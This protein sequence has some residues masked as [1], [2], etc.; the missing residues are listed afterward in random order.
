MSNFQSPQGIVLGSTEGFGFQVA[1][2]VWKF[3]RN[4]HR[5]EITVFSIFFKYVNT[6]FY[7]AKTRGFLDK[8]PD[9]SKQNSKLVLLFPMATHCFPDS[10]N[11]GGRA[12]KM[13]FLI[14]FRDLFLK[15][16]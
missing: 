15:P 1:V 12:P 10:L 2:H 7:R 3:E 16:K 4:G 11:E 13:K 14:K 6:M 5:G 9:I 8:H